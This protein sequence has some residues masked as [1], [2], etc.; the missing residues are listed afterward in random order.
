MKHD[1]TGG[2]IAIGLLA[3]LGGVTWALVYAPIPADNR[4]PITV[5]I[6]VLSANIGMVVGYYFGSSKSSRGKDDVIASLHG[7][8]RER[9]EHESGLLP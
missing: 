2:F 5:L 8:K 9:D 6:G 7:R 1:I 4:E 3:I